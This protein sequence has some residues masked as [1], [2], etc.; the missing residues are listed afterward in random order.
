[1]A[2][3]FCYVT[4]PSPEAA[5]AIARRLVEERLAAGVNVLPGARSVYRWEGIV[6]DAAEAVLVVKTRS[7]LVE[8]VTRRVLELHPHRCPGVA[9]L[10]VV[11]GNPDYL[12]WIAAETEVE[13]R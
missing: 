10:P 1:M 13:E 4:C 12:A 5:L 3:V 9:A 7:A 6:R 11:G 8:A 2:T